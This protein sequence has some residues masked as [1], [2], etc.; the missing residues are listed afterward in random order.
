MI[1]YY[2]CVALVALFLVIDWDDDDFD[3]PPP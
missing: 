2:F 1:L 3:L